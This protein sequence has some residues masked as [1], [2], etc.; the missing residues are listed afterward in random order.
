MFSGIV[1]EIGR[2]ERAQQTA[3]GRRVTI[4]CQTALEG[5]RIGDSI[6]VDGVC[7]TVAAR[8]PSSFAADI[9]PVTA[10]RST[11]GDTRPGSQVNL[12]RSVV[13]GGRIGGHY[14]QGHVDGIG[15]IVGKRGEGTAL[16]VEIAAS[17]DV[18]RY[19]VER[20][21]IAVDGASLTVVA[22]GPD[23]LVVS[24]V[25]HTQ[26]H[27]TLPQLPLGAAVNLEAD[28]IAKYVERL[29]TPHRSEGF[30][31]ETL[32]RAGFV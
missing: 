9:Q 27:L 6:A 8:S 26:Q 2:I 29:I 13:A 18:L 31:L 22:L 10:R 24:L 21:F 32:V 28:V 16:V 20:G 3:S 14:V 15:R 12:E 4:A 7:L 1:E 17:H 5:T 23:R 11:L 30:T 25:S 19:A